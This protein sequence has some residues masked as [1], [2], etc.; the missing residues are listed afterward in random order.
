M[1]KGLFAP[2]GLCLCAKIR[3]ED[4]DQSVCQVSPFT[5]KVMTQ[6]TLSQVHSIDLITHGQ[7]DRAS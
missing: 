4:D 2:A 5:V 7:E 6:L 3:R 1:M